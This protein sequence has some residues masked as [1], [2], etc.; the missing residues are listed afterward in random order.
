M[1]TVEPIALEGKVVE[2][3]FIGKSIPRVDGQ[4]KVTGEAKFSTDIQLPGML[5]GKIKRSPYPFAR[6]IAIHTDKA[7]RLPGVRGIVSAKDVLQFPYGPVIADELALADKYA[8]YVGDEVAAVAAIDEETAE[9]AADLIEV[10]YE[11]LTPVLDPEKGGEPG[12]LEVHPEREEV[13]Q[14]VAFHV[15]FTRGE[16]EAAFKRADV[17]VTDHFTTQVQHQAYL[18]PNVC[19]AQWS[20]TGKLTV[21]GSTQAPFRFRRLLATALGIPEHRIR[22]IQPY[23]GGGFGGKTYLYPHFP[24][25]AFLAKKTGKP[26]K[27]TYTRKEDF[28]A[29]RPR[30]TEIIDL[31]LGFKKDGTMVAKSVVVT[32]DSG[33]YVGACPNIVTTSLI[34]PDCVYRLPNITAVANV[35]YTNKIPRSPFRG[36]GNPEMLF[37]T[38]SLIDTAAERLGI[39]PMEIRLKNSSQKGDTTV[40]G[41]I[42]NSCG[43]SDCIKLA[44]E[45]SAWKNKRQKPEQNVGIG[46]ACQVHVAG[47]RAVSKEYDGSAAIINVDQYGKARVFSGESEIGQGMLTVFTQ[48]TA[49]ELGIRIQDVDVFP[50]VDSDFCPIGH[51]TSAS[52]VTTLGGNAV[53]LAARDAKKQ[54]LMHAATKLGISA[55]DLVINDNKF[56]V[57]G[58]SKEIATVPEV[59]YDTVL[60]KLGGVPITGRGEY[61]VPDYVVMPDKNKYGNYAVSYAFSAQVIEVSVDTETGKVNV[62]NVWV[63]EDIGKVLNPKL[64]EGQIEGGVVQGMG[65]AL[66]EDYFWERG[67]TLNPNFTDY[68]IPQ[69]VGIPRIY[70]IF[71]E[72]NDPEGPFGGKC[73]GEPAMNP[74]AA[75]IANAIHHAVGVR[76]KSLPITP[77]KIL[78][79]LKDKSKGPAANLSR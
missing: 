42:L 37:A 16:G 78:N 32:A 5:Y 63:G 51:G 2:Y 33:A 72:T 29:G 13:K 49:E 18:E 57:K 25:C 47:N 24:I 11:E 10:E 70:S 60:K 17:I 38:E 45:K 74:T 62:L 12:A 52:R 30:M 65:Y 67:K 14:N 19:V 28:I 31:K 9:E 66:S 55:D 7:R 21:I 27:I 34:R 46:I 4:E 69:S 59:A 48:I 79:A 35:V 6:I 26:V 44:A 20:S 40:H 54:L 77:E 8:R 39:D 73:I 36:Y 56:Y 58:S 23:V 43:L 41:W 68:K 50:F 71:V 3:S 75:A 22:I 53:R 1:A 15:E 61:I 76:I 64:C